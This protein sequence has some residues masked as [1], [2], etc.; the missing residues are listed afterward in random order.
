MRRR[1][2]DLYTAPGKGRMKKAPREE[3]GLIEES[4]DIFYKK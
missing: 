4:V 3:Y 1:T 2:T